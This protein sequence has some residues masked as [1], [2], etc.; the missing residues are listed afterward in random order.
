MAGAHGAG[1]MVVPFV[2]RDVPAAHAHAGHAMPAGVNGAQLTAW[3]ST[4]LHTTSYLLVCGAIALLVYK[5]LG[6]QF[7]RTSWINLDVIWAVALICTAAITLL[8]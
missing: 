6:L 8:I 1:L 5:K 7:L 2:L 4:L 3:S